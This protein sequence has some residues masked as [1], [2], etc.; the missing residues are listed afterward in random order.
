MGFVMRLS[1]TPD[2]KTLA[3]SVVG[4]DSEIWVWENLKPNVSNRPYRP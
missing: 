3:V 1:L 2:G 4:G